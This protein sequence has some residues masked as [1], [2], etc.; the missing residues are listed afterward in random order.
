MATRFEFL[1]L[2]E[3][4]P[5]LRAA[6][7]DVIREIQRI[8]DTFSFYRQQSTLSRLNA[9]ACNEA[10]PVNAEVFTF[11]QKVAELSR[12]TDGA[13]DP[14]VGPLM[15]AWGFTGKT[16]IKPDDGQIRQILEH[17]GMRHVLLD[18]KK[19]T[20]R[21]VRSGVLLD[22]GAVGKGYA[23]DE[24]ARL[25]Q[26]MG[27]KHALIH[28]G[29]SS[30]KAWGD[31]P[32]GN[33]WQVA[34][35]HPESVES[36]E[37]KLLKVIRLRNEAMSVSTVWGKTF[38]VEGKI[39]GHVIDPGKGQPAEGA[40]LTVC[41]GKSAMTADACSTAMLVL[42]NKSGSVIDRIP[43]ITGFFIILNNKDIVDRLP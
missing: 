21:F 24:A 16:G 17:T 12:K 1:L 40:L 6:G 2:G 25:L 11:L 32:E 26:E 31:S 35:R 20:V 3:N 8:E 10:V 34:V 5:F 39:L 22:P 4:E 42:A 30:V 36:D 43:G 13:F 28:G 29:T 14:T 15:K 19:R 7:E 37:V 41:T 18:E 9:K 33:G 27:V 23:L 38:E